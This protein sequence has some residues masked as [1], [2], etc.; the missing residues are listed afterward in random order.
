[1]L[2]ARSVLDAITQADFGMCKSGMAAG[3]K[4][5]TFCGTPD[6]V[7]PELITRQPYDASIDFWCL[8]ILVYEC[9][10]GQAPY[11]PALRTI[12]V[13][14]AGQGRS[15]GRGRP[16]T[17]CTLRCA[18][19]TALLFTRDRV[20]GLAGSTVTATMRCGA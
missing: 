15:R 13:K 16:S 6:Y 17:L 4:T 19:R 14:P 10:T 12:N 7:S 5:S 2:S 3:V 1:M 9:I 8:G 20:D 11:V 18:L